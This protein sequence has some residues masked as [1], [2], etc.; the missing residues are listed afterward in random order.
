MAY[1]FP[2]VI[3]E[4][5][6]Y[7]RQVNVLDY[8]F[9]VSSSREKRVLCVPSLLDDF[10]HD[11][12]RDLRLNVIKTQDGTKP[13]L[14]DL[15]WRENLW[16][17]NPL[18]GVCELGEL[19]SWS[20]AKAE[21]SWKNSAIADVIPLHFSYFLLTTWP[22]MMES[23]KTKVRWCVCNV[24]ACVHCGLGRSDLIK[25]KMDTWEI[26]GPKIVVQELGWTLH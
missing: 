5:R 1:S 20:S 26:V 6:V 21:P 2:Q 12:K 18:G 23:L 13:R 4:N 3:K 14:A 8:L 22:L 11:E 25:P 9:L 19:H 24:D 16:W 15:H 10:K 7:S 17:L